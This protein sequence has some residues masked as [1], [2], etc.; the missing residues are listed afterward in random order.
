[1]DGEGPGRSA[2]A[3]RIISGPL[4]G[5][6]AICEGMRFGE[7]LEV[8]LGLLRINVARAAIEALLKRSQIRRRLQ[9]ALTARQ[10]FGASSNIAMRASHREFASFPESCSSARIERDSS[11]FSLG[12]GTRERTVPGQFWR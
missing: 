8:L 10:C 3:V 7:W 6:L 12:S 2:T 9:M 11:R 4:E 5:N 1:M